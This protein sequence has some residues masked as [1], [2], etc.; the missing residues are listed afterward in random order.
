MH[1]HPTW[2]APNVDTQGLMPPVPMAIRYLQRHAAAACANQHTF[3][4]V[5]PSTRLRRIA[6]TEAPPSAAAAAGTSSS[7]SSSR[8][9]SGSS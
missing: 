3:N 7:S 8:G 5:L 9:T 1:Q 4:L 6:L 2:S